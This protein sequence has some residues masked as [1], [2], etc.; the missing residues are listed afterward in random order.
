ML[1]IWTDIETTGLDREKDLIL[2]VC[3]RVT[4]TD[5]S[6]VSSFKTVICYD[7]DQVAASL[8]DWAFDQHTD[9]GLL[10]EIRDGKGMDWEDASEVIER[11][12]AS[13]PEEPSRRHLA[14]RNVGVFDLQFLLRDFP[15]IS[16]HVSFRVVD[17]SVL[18]KTLQ[19]LL[20][21][22]VTYP[23]GKTHRAEDDVTDTIQQFI[24]YRERASLAVG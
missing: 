8:N 2:E 20:E 23:R 14:G 6:P 3:F 15:F 16:D 18:E 21:R 9:N 5:L 10:A 7:Y 19:A 22:D 4:R 11:F 17:L 24:W 1:L 13:L 12:F